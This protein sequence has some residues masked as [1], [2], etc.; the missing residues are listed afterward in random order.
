LEAGEKPARYSRDIFITKRG[1]S[2]PLMATATFAT[3]PPTSVQGYITAARGTWFYDYIKG[4][5][6]QDI[7][8][9]YQVLPNFD[10]ILLPQ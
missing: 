8:I 7:E 10:I 3:L 9:D 2:A 6:D 5:M 4:K 1:E